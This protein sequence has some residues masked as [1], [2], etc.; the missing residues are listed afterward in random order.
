MPLPIISKRP[1]AERGVDAYSAFRTAAA[2]FCGSRVRIFR[3]TSGMPCAGTGGI[4]Y[5]LRAAGYTVMPSTGANT[6]V[7]IAPMTS[8]I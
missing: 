4:V 3:G 8:T 7:R 6:D 1:Q 5:L 2:L